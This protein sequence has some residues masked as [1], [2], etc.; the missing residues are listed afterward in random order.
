MNLNPPIYNANS[1][2]QSSNAQPNHFTMLAMPPQSQTHDIFNN[3]NVSNSLYRDQS[4]NQSLPH[5]SNS[6]GLFSEGSFSEYPNHVQANPNLFPSR[7]AERSSSSL[8]VFSRHLLQQDLLKK[9][10][11]PFD[12]KAVNFWP[13]YSKITSYSKDL[14][15]SP[16]QT[17]QLFE[18]HCRGEPQR[19]LTNKLAAL[20][21]VTP[22]DARQA[23]DSLI[24]R[25]G[26][27]QRI[28]T[29]L[30]S[31]VDSFPFIKGADIGNQLHNLHELCSI[32]LF[33]MRKCRELSILDLSTGLKPLRMKLATR[34]HSK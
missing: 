22:E 16:L 33:N 23:I 9:T 3:S 10:I 34:F 21:E 15:L 4:F 5:S 24:I 2:S 29:E 20:G 1:R 17:L 19:M 31:K 27:T 30:F 18:N 8:E 11:E 26:S 32:L 14:L 7:H 6:F 28:T 13:W 25:F 12:G